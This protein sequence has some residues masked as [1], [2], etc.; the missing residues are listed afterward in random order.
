MRNQFVRILGAAFFAAFLAACQS[1]S[2]K[3]SQ[4]IARGQEYYDGE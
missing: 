3:I 2:E 1:D 4:H